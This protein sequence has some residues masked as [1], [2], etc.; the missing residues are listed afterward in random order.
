MLLTIAASLAASPTTESRP[1]RGLAARPRR[2]AAST[3]CFG[4]LSVVLWQG[5]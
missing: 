1:R 4:R 3:T 5:T 2:N